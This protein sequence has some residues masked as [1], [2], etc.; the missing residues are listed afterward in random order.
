VANIVRSKTKPKLISSQ[1]VTEIRIDFY[2]LLHPLPWMQL[3][4]QS[5]WDYD[6]RLCGLVVRVLGYRSGGP[7]SIAGTTRKKK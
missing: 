1:K 3:E 7:G 4:Y 2:P 5:S 6:D